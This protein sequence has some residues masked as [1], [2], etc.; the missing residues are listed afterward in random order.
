MSQENVYFDIE[1]HFICQQRSGQFRPA[2]RLPND[3]H[4]CDSRNVEAT[5]TKGDHMAALEFPRGV[6]LVQAPDGTPGHQGRGMWQ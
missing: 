4:F 3:S 5:M 2:S 6:G 1:T